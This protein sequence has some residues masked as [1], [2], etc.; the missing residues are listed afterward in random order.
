[1]NHRAQRSIRRRAI[2]VSASVALCGLLAAAPPGPGSPPPGLQGEDLS[3]E[4]CE[5]ITAAYTRGLRDFGTGDYRAAAESFRQ[6]LEV[7]PLDDVAVYYLAAAYAGAGN[8]AVSLLWLNRLR[9]LESCLRPTFPLFQSLR[10]TEELRK[11]QRALEQCSTCSPRSEIVVELAQEDVI[12]GSMAFDAVDGA[13][14]FGDLHRGWI[15]RAAPAGDGRY[16]SRRFFEAGPDGAQV[17]SGMK[18]DPVRRLLWVAAS[19]GRGAADPGP[20]ATGGSA[21]FALDLGTAERVAWLEPESGRPHLLADIALSPNGDVAVA[22]QASGEIWLFRG[23]SR[24]LE[25]LVP[26]GVL[27][28]PACVAF[29]ADGQRLFAADRDRPGIYRADV[30]GGTVKCLPHCTGPAP[31]GVEGLHFLD[32][33]LIAVVPGMAGGRVLRLGLSQDFDR[34]AAIDVIDCHHPPFVHPAA[35]TA[36]SRYLYYLANTG[37]P[38]PPAEGKPPARSPNRNYVVLKLRL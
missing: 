36:S 18:V 25:L 38:G 12:P 33:C 29:S 11:V 37:Y 31:V 14:F 22:D 17:I 27:H 34:I 15:I 19:T 30:R 28:S 1:M 20:A 35:G 6:A 9:E 4:Q 7:N 13:F 32:D 21:L 8:A 23:D 3:A 26:G 24:V 2:H 10:A 5:R 16:S